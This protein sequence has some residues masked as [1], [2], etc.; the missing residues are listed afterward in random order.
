MTATA[1]VRQFSRRDAA[2]SGMTAL[3]DKAAHGSAAIRPGT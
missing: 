3:N 1:L 2:P